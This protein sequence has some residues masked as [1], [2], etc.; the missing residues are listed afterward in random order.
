ML[1]RI[2]LII[3]LIPLFLVG[4][5]S[6]SESSKVT[7]EF[8]TTTAEAETTALLDIAKKF[9][10]QHPSIKVDVKEVEFGKAQNQFKTATLSNQAPDILRS[11]I[12]WTTEFADLDILLPLDDKVSEEDKEDY[13]ES[14]F[15]YN[16][17]EDHIYGIPMVTDSP[18]LIYNKRMLKEAG[19]NEAP[20]T[21]DELLMMSKALTNENQ[22]GVFISPDSYYALPYVWAF[23]GGMISDDKEILINNEGSRNGINF[24]L[25]LMN[26]K[27]VQPELQFDNWNQVMM[28]DFKAGKVAMIINGPWAT[29]DILSGAEFKNAE[30]LGIA[31]VPAGP[32]G[33]GSPVGGHNLVI[34]N[35]TQAPDEAYQFIEF[36]NNREN[37]AYLAKEL[38]ILPTR[39]SAYEDEE[40]LEN[41]IF[42]GFKS[43]LEVATSRPVI[44]EGPLLLNDFSTYLPKILLKEVS[45]E[46][47]LNR[48]ED[49]WDYLIN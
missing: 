40:L 48:I 47:G 13:F 10:K 20:K 37:Q 27:V 41:Q 15:K 30:N 4:C 43:Q 38:G 35:Y 3:L 19:F 34:S 42:Q 16:M 44:P 2:I 8:W 46:E 22:Y 32:A 45:T 12:A 26:E 18:A 33:Q 7:L 25:K 29:T 5:S 49:S 21:M 9:E 23:G 28:D 14:A 1:R 24:M 11:D 31:P 36:L 39:Q 17:Y 6:S